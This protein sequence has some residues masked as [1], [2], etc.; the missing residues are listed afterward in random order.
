MALRNAMLICGASLALSCGGGTSGGTSTPQTPVLS[1][2]GSY[3]T[4]ATLISGNCGD[5]VQNNVT[6]VTHTPGAQTLSLTHANI[7]ATGTIDNTG[8]FSTTAV[9]GDLAITIVGQFSGT[10]FDATVTLRHSQPACEYT[11]HWVGTKTG[12]PNTYP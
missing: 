10:G 9:L 2:G 6:T 5:Q 3:P 4:V 1:V 11:V 8:R 12:P 7:N